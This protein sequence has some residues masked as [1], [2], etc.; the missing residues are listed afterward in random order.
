M[1]TNNRYV[2]W[3]FILF[4]SFICPAYAANDIVFQP[5]Q[6]H[7]C[8]T[9]NGGDSKVTLPNANPQL[10]R[11]DHGNWVKAGNN[12][13]N[14]IFSAFPTYGSDCQSI[15]D[16]TQLTLSLY[17]GTPGGSNT[18]VR[19]YCAHL[20]PGHGWTNACTGAPTNSS[21]SV[22]YNF[23]LQTHASGPGDYFFKI[24]PYRAIDPPG[25]V[26]YYPFKIVSHNQFVRALYKPT[27]VRVV[28]F[29]ANAYLMSWQDN[30]TNNPLSGTATVEWKAYIYNGTLSPS[31]DLN[32]TVYIIRSNS[33]PYGSPPGPGFS[34]RVRLEASGQ[35]TVYSDWVTIQ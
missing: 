32:D 29:L 7:S 17:R 35:T 3:L 11:N 26:A 2:Y 31:A 9:G 4:L 27:N 22:S 12:T 34:Y 8:L 5:S 30:N 23:Q 20:I 18:L 15:L 33:G 19:V 24:G 28:P 1:H 10:V 21:G 25:L 14:A 6:G 16:G 13:I